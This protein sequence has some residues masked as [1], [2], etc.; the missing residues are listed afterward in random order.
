MKTK[1]FILIFLTNWFFSCFSKPAAWLDSRPND[2]KYWH[3]IGFASH[4][5]SNN[6]K[7]LAK[8]YAIHEISSQIKVNI[9]SELDI[10][11][12][13]T[14][15]AIDNVI[16]SVMNSRVNL[17]LPELELVDNYITNKGVYFYVRLNKNNYYRTIERLR[18][19]AKEIS[20]NYVIQ[21]NKEFGKRS[22]ILIQ[23]AWQEI[24][25]FNDEPIEVQ[26]KN[27]KYNL[28]SLVRQKYED[29]TN[30]ISVKAFLQNENIRTIIDRDN[31]LTIK[32]FDKETGKMLKDI[33][34]K[35]EQKVMK[36]LPISQIKKVISM[37]ILVIKLKLQVWNLLFLDHAR[38]FDG[39]EDRENI[40]LSS[41]NLGSI[42]INV[43]PSKVQII[44]EE[45]NLSKPLKS[46]ILEP[47]VKEL[48]SGHVEFVK[49]NP[50]FYLH[51]NA[52]TLVKANNVEPGFPFF[53]YCNA[54]V[55]LIDAENNQE[56]FM[57]NIADIKG[58]DFGSFRTAGIRAY[59]QMKSKILQELQ[60][61]L[62]NL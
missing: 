62:L 50:D 28:F 53:S 26:Y 44:S 27:Q 5:D 38:L 48:L 42:N 29:Y 45:K 54:S 59:D 46:P 58:G 49:S 15:G 21:S 16:K 31:I 10:I 8:E 1:I 40:L 18:A 39:E 37:L 4:T 56:F 32:V 60:K 17:L 34:I 20:L 61:N 47:E 12:S 6:P 36:V 22:L 7:M 24:Y 30:R 9:S 51:I 2:P 52:N 43:V 23:N 25:P 41:K 13:D 35:I 3:G 19:N 14:N 33:P 55:S 11:T 57:A